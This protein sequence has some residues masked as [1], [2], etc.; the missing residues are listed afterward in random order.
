MLKRLRDVHQRDETQ[1]LYISSLDG[2]R[3]LAFLAVFIH[4]LP[5]STAILGLERFQKRGWVGVELFFVISAFLFFHLFDAEHRK[6]GFIDVKRFYLR[7]FLRIYP[8]MAA[9]PVAM[10]IWTGFYTK[11][12]LL[13]LL[14]LLAGIDN[15]VTAVAGYSPV[16]YSPQLWTLSFE[17]QI[18]LVIPFAFMAYRKYGSR[19]FLI[20]AAAFWGVC[21]LSRIAAVLC[22][23]GYLSAWVLPFLRPDSVLLGMLLSIFAQRVSASYALAAGTGAG[24]VFFALP[25]MEQS[26]LSQ[27]LVFPAAAILCAS[28]VALT[29]A[30]RP[31]ARLMS[32]RWFTFAGAI[33]F[34]LYVFHVFGIDLARRFFEGHGVAMA[35]ISAAN[36]VALAFAAFAITFAFC[37]ASYVGLERPFLRLKDRFA[38]VH[39][40]PAL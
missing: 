5:F 33:S 29:L 4:H 3:L 20:G 24:L 34:G 15:L 32:L 21:T 18:Y 38:A 8:L 31:L 23:A 10:I 17:F 1:T 25:P 27:I 6:N 28:L 22:G 19:R 30:W 11:E 13:R 36:G 7:R 2:L 37:V 35:P 40:R 14:G 9:F 26:E 12:A 39:G 16:P